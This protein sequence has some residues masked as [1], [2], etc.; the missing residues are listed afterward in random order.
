[1]ISAGARNIG[2]CTVLVDPNPSAPMIWIKPMRQW[3]AEEA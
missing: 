2:A 1:L 3:S